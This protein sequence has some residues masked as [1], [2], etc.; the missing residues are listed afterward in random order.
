MVSPVFHRTVD[1]VSFVILIIS[2]H[3]DIAFVIEVLFRKRI[4]SGVEKFPQVSRKRFLGKRLCR[5]TDGAD[6]RYDNCTVEII[7]IY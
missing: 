4:G 5:A 6:F 1:G 2:K 7:K 3:S